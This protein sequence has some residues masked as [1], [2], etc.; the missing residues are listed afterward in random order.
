[1]PLPR[2][3]LARNTNVKTKFGKTKEAEKQETR[4]KDVCSKHKIGGLDFTDCLYSDPDG[5]VT[6][7][8]K[9][10]ILA[11]LKLGVI[12]V[13]YVP[14]ETDDDIEIP[15][16]DLIKIAKDKEERI[17]SNK[18]D[19]N[20]DDKPEEIINEINE[21]HET[22]KENVQEEIVDDQNVEQENEQNIEQENVQHNIE[23]EQ[24]N[25][26]NEQDQNEELEEYKPT[27][28]ERRQQARIN[29]ASVKRQKALERMRADMAKHESTNK[30]GNKYFRNFMKDL[31]KFK[32]EPVT[33][34]KYFEVKTNRTKMVVE[35]PKVFDI[36][37][38][39]SKF[40]YRMFIGDLQMKSHVMK[41]IDPTIEMSNIVDDH[42]DFLERIKADKSVNKIIHDDDSDS[43]S[44]NESDQE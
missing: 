20:N 32:L 17:E 30:N 28:A 31:A 18:T 22:T 36:T 7:M 38:K 25:D 21:L 5:N 12:I 29:A 35:D 42:N 37:V 3:K 34:I 6:Y 8:D 24:E 41:R 4:F 2:N 16:Y 14:S 26:S 9:Q 39:L 33:N 1:M 23:Q 15:M 11:N 40:T 27:R 13:K 43:D 10:T 19:E 44:D